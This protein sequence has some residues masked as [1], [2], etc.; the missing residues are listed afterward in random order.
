MTQAAQGWARV[1]L[2][3]V[4]ALWS[5][6][7]LI[8]RA[9][10]DVIAPHALAFGRWGLAA[11]LLLPFTARGLL[12][13]REALRQEWKHLVVLGILGMWICGAWMYHGGQRTSA[14]NMALIYAVTPIA[15]AIVGARLLHERML[16][17]QWFGAVL[18]LLGLLIVIG[19]GDIQRLRHLRAHVAQSWQE[20]VSF[21]LLTPI[22]ETDEE[23]TVVNDI[24][25]SGY[26]NELAEDERILIPVATTSINRFA[27]LADLARLQKMTELPKRYRRDLALSGF[28]RAALQG[29]EKEA[30]AFA[31]A[32]ESIDESLGALF[33][34]WRGAADADRKKFAVVL[35]DLQQPGFSIDLWESWGRNLPREELSSTR[36]NWWCA[37]SELPVDPVRPSFLRGLEAPDDASF[38]WSA[39]PNH[40]GREVLA[41]A[42]K[43]PDDPRLPEALHRTVRATR[44]G[45]YGEPFAEV[46][47]GAFTLLHK[48]FP[49]TDWAKQTPYWFE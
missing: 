10:E 19:Q 8:A 22:G 49:K 38:G 34:D 24:D 16:P 6:N 25:V 29:K 39:G 20:L 43:Y 14:T 3:V 33:A 2:W 37:I 11:L 12:R 13:Q 17:R 31:K 4:P 44:L 47:K 30:E 18:A 7:Y 23:G 41:Y 28:L 35:M 26:N 48:R 42:A 5:T 9:S 40:L 21:G 45:C 1:L 46:S 32:A 15:I 36:E 27:S